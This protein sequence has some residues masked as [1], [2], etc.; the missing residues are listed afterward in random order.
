M[1][2][3]RVG[4]IV[5]GCA[6]GVRTIDKRF[7]FHWTTGFTDRFVALMVRSAWTAT[8]APASTKVVRNRSIDTPSR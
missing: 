4:W 6:P 7:L 8:L 2:K 3:L 5:G 1:A